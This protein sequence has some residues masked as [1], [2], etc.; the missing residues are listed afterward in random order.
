MPKH[1][2]RIWLTALVLGWAVDFLF[3]KHAPGISYAIW[4]LLIILAAVFITASEK[5]RPAWTSW[6]LMLASLGLATF[7]FIR[8]EEFTVFMSVASSMGLLLL[9][10][11][12]LRTGYWARYRL[13]DYLLAGLRMLWAF[14][15]RPI[16]HL[17]NLARTEPEKSGGSGLR[18]FFRVIGP[19]LL[20]FLIAVPV[21]L[22]LGGLL[23]SA[24]PVFSDLLAK[25][26]DLRR[27]PEYIFRLFYILFFT[28]GFT[29]ALL[30]AVLPLKDEEAPDPQKGWLKPFLGSTEA[31]VVLVLVNLLFAFFVAIQFRYLFG[32]E[33]NITATG[34]T[35]SEYARR[36]FNELVAVAVLSLLL[37][38]GLGTITRLQTDGHRR[39]F[40]LLTVALMGLV[41]VILA[42]AYQRLTLYEDA[43]GFTQ[44]RTYTHIFMAWLALLLLA[45]IVFEV[46]RRRGRFALALLVVGVGFSLTLGFINVDGFIARQNVERAVSG[47]ELDASYLQ[48]L[49]VD[50]VPA[51]VGLYNQPNLPIAVRDSLGAELACRTARLEERQPD[52]WQSFHLARYRAAQLLTI[53]QGEWSAYPVSLDEYGRS[54]VLVDGVQHSCYLYFYD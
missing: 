10:A 52:S 8:S 31:V 37:Y 12:T 26:F 42:S 18:R 40:S 1:S 34:Y 11:A 41:I 32:G 15:S 20:G 33:A 13:V 2:S 45:G 50:A 25:L 49:S 19:I 6:L 51:L 46:V 38:L 7:S 43:Y 36:G 21:L 23:A 28:Y 4:V 29:G 54:Q 27:L 48:R 3:W 35:Y 9:L 53:H 47:A 44:L 16:I 5:V 24:D 22:V 14:V 17:Q 39:T 30:H